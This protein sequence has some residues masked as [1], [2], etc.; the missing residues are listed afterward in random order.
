MRFSNPE[1]QEEKL[2]ATINSMR[3]TSKKE[4]RMKIS[5]PSRPQ[6]VPGYVTFSKEETKK[7]KQLLKDSL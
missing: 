6:D 5:D 4:L 3:I 1:N 2:D 7:I